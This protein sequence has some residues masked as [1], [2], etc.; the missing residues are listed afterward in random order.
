MGQMN[1]ALTTAL[2]P[3]SAA[4]PCLSWEA[5]LCK[6]LVEISAPQPS[7]CTSYAVHVLLQAQ[8]QGETV[9]WIQPEGGPLYPPDLQDSGVDVEAVVVIQVP[10]GA[11]ALGGPKAAEILLR[12]GAFGLVVLDLRAG[13]PR[14][15]AS[16]WQGRLLGL[17]RQHQSCVLLLTHKSPH[18]ESLG[19]W[20]SW[21]LQPERRPLGERMFLLAPQVLKNKM[22]GAWPLGAQQYR[23]PWGLY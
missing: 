1:A 20:V 14:G 18:A 6:R 23:G 9:A 21:R 22:G 12:S 2:R 17:A 19:A 16:A 5:L 11:G 13:V 10:A 4:P 15:W 8:R 7:G 3:V